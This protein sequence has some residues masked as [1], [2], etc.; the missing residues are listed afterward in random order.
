MGCGVAPTAAT[1]QKHFQAA[2]AVNEGLRLVLKQRE[3]SKIRRRLADFDEAVIDANLPEAAR[4]A[5]TVETWWPAI[6]V[7]LIHDVSNART[8]GFNPG[9][10]TDQAGRLRVQITSQLPA[11]YPQPHRGHPTT[12]ISSMNASQPRSNSKSR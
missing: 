1:Q 7:A 2:W 3:P 12:K 10:Q 6:L 11:P 8:E 4:L 9:D 5:R